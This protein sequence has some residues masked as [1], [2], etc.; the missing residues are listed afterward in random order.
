[1][2]DA[3]VIRLFMIQ[4]LTVKRR[5]DEYYEYVAKYVITMDEHCKREK[6]YK[7]EHDSTFMQMSYEEKVKLL[8]QN[9]DALDQAFDDFLEN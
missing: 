7:A 3:T 6:R 4:M 8:L 9:R 5:S 2:P 1:M